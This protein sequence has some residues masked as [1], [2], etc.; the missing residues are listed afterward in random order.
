MKELIRKSIV[1]LVLMMMLINSSLLLIISKAVDAIENAIDES[2]INPL[3][4]I[5]LEK[6][7]NYNTESETGTI[8]QMNLKTGIE[9]GEGIEYSPLSSMGV[10]L[11]LPKIEGEYPSS[12]EVIGKSTK[13]TNGIDTGKDIENNYNTETGAL[14]IVAVNRE[15]EN[16]NI[17]R[18]N[19]NGA[20]DEYT[21]ILYY[22]SNCYTDANI[23]RNL[24]ISGFVQANIENEEGTNKQAEIKQNYEVTENISG[25]ISTNVKTSEIY[26]GY[27]SANSQNETNYRTEYTENVDINISKKEISDEMTMSISNAFINK[28]EKTVETQEVIYKSTKIDKNKILDILGQE[29]YLKIQNENGDVLGEVNKDTEVNENGIYEVKYENEINKIVIK[30][31]KPVKV[32][33]I[34]IENTREIKETV[35]DVN[36]NRIQTNAVIRC[37]N[38]IQETVIE[39]DEETKE[40]KEV[41]KESTKEIYKY[42][43]KN[44]TEI[45]DA[46]TRIDM[47]ISNTNWTNNIQN[48]ITFNATLVANSARYNLFKNPTIEIKL[49]QEV[50]K[51]ILGEASLV[52]GEGLTKKEPEVIEKDGCKVIRMQIE[53]SQVEYF[54]NSMVD[55]VNVIIPATIIVRK[56]IGNTETNVS[57]TYTNENGNV[58]D[59]QIGGAENKT[60]NVNI[61]AILEE[62]F[63]MKGSKVQANNDVTNVQPQNKN[64]T[65]EL[66]VKVEAILG[67]KVLNDGDIVH[68]KQIIKYAVTVTNK[69]EETISGISIEG[70][71]PEGTVYAT[72]DIGSYMKEN[73][74]Y[75]EEPDKKTVQITL[76]GGIA[77]GQTKTEF[78]EVKV[79]NL[80]EGETEK[81][82]SNTISVKIDDNVYTQET[83]TSIIKKAEM[84][85]Y[86][87]SYIGREKRNSFWYYIDITN[88]TDKRINNV[89]IESNELQEE[90]V[91]TEKPTFYDSFGN[92]EEGKR[93]PIGEIN[94]EGKYVGNIE[95]M[96]PGQTRTILMVMTATNFKDNINEC[97]LSMI[98]SV[99]SDNTDTYI[100]NENRRT[101]YPEYVTAI[102]ELD[103][104]GQNVAPGETIQYKFTIEN[105]SKV[106]T[107]VNL[108]DAFSEFL[109]DVTV[110]YN[111]Y[112]IDEWIY[113]DEEN[114]MPNGDPIE[115]KV[116][117]YTTWYDLEKEK[118]LEYKFEKQE[119][120]ISELEKYNQFETNT[121]IP[122][123]KVLEVIVT[124]TVKEVFETT[125]VRN[126]M[127]ASGDMLK[128]V[129]TNISKF[130][131]LKENDDDKDP[132]DKD[133]D[134]FVLL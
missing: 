6:Y 127:I 43:D 8:V 75:V 66:D 56:D 55:G 5:N 131:I 13:A 2:K 63:M 49:P 90:L 106:R 92:D 24:E 62:Q 37:I 84:E 14:E 98:L 96:E 33:T 52:Y 48:D 97:L 78:Y 15:D 44:V 40:E 125:E 121:I 113:V 30:T 133:D 16:G 93:I 42:E 51:V 83:E 64:Y 27:I 20:R 71:V 1:I 99:S 111:E 94:E 114:R 122:A 89:K 108:K 80:N 119:L 28:S 65:D 134:N 107:L 61:D 54:I 91:L 26:N 31:S 95:Y 29:G 123:G 53:G 45:K 110:K 10:N 70:Q 105:K 128:T 74:S 77:A 58:N 100:S 116:S 18:E 35:V 76:A 115:L 79:N 39:T 7:V 81:N 38:N 85:V 126:Y 21:V 46:E 4:E 130:T 109:E 47:S 50:E 67:D 132:D 120:N 104:E 87:N 17:Y 118:N 32:G 112:S 57:F 25:L 34:Q 103:K 82:I 60:I 88:L 41:V 124:G 9:Y 59:Y 86:I 3:Y 72:V 22:G 19:V 11:N 69:S 12:V 68:E 73:Y 23:K 129:T 102:Q 101:A 36:I 117:P